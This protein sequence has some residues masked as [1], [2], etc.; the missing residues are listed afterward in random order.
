MPAPGQP[1]LRLR[2]EVLDRLPHDTDAYTQG[3]VLSDGRLFESTGLEGQSDVREVD[4]A[5]GR[6]VRSTPLAKDQF[7]EGLAAVDDELVQLTWQNG[8][9]LVWDRDTLQEQ[10]RA[11]YRGEGWGLC[12]DGVT[13]RLVQTDGSSTLIFRDPTT[14]A[15]LGRVRVTLDGKPL[16]QLNELECTTDGVWANVWQTSSIVRID[17]PAAGSPRSS[18]PTAWPRPTPTRQTCSTASPAAP[19]APGS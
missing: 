15:E 4:P 6:V 8:V 3:L 17:P 2:V 1:P 18:T 11:S 9:A 12:F 14:F 10:R 5:T 16:E 7:G 19:T 13:D